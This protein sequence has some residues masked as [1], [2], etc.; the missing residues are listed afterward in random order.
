MAFPN[1]VKRPHKAFAPVDTDDP[2]PRSEPPSLHSYFLLYAAL[3]TVTQ[4]RGGGRRNSISDHG[5]KAGL[6]DI[7]PLQDANPSFL[8]WKIPEPP[9]PNTIVRHDGQIPGTL[10]DGENGACVKAIPRRRRFP[11][12]PSNSLGLCCYHS[13]IA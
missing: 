11:L 10:V 3:L 8:H 1:L 13:L 7:E 6:R 9:G 12:K 4:R 2:L 5:V